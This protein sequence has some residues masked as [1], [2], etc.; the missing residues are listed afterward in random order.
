MKDGKLWEQIKVVKA[1]L[2]NV[3]RDKFYYSEIYKKIITR[4]CPKPDLFLSPVAKPGLLDADDYHIVPIGHLD[5]EALLWF[6]RAVIDDLEKQEKELDEE[7]ASLVS[8]HM[9]EVSNG[10]G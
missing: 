5:H 4:E 1:K 6:L 2:V 3:E 8:R 9:Q 7:Y 10:G